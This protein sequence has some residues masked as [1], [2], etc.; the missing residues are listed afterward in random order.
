MKN[1]ITFLPANKKV[2][3]SVPPPK[4][5]KLSIPQ[6]F[7]DVPAINEKNLKVDH[8]GTANVNVKNCMPFLDVFTS[9][10]IQ[11]TWTDIYIDKDEDGYVIYN[12]SGISGPEIMKNRDK[13]DLPANDF[14]YNFEFIWSQLWIPKLDDGYSCLFINP[15]NRIELPFYT[16]SAIVDSDKMNYSGGGNIPFY[17]KKDFVGL[18]PA[19]TP[20]YQMIPFKRES[21]EMSTEEYNDDKSFK[22][23][24][25]LRK[26]FVGAYRKNL[27]SKK[28]FS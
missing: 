19:G 18:I 22:G 17:I 25:D 28:D 16:I 10:Y 13:S 27:W 9:G 8:N 4:P 11:E 15:V 21:W 6:W 24:N 12:Q 5:A 1:K 7:K 14:F 2:E 23:L 26:K 3:L 20:M